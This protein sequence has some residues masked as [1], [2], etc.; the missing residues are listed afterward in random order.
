MK[1]IVFVR[2]LFDIF[3]CDFSSDCN[4]KVLIAGSKYCFV[5]K[6]IFMALAI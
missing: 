2:L 6:F 4:Q 3:D 5:P 1:K